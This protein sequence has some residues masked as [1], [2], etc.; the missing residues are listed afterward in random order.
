MYVCVCK[1]VTDSDIRTAMDAGCHTLPQLRKELGV[2]SQ[3]GRCAGCACDM[4]RECRHHHHHHV[5][6]ETAALAAA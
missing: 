6:S 5:P 4:L 1:A 2:A 3:C